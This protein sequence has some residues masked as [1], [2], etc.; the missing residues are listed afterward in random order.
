M[1]L[2]GRLALGVQKH[3]AWTISEIAC[4]LGFSVTR[5]FHNFFQKHVRLSLLK[6]RS[7]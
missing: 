6:F 2:K 4:E 7:V 3:T 5:H 1:E